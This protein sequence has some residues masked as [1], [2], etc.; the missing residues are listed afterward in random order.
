MHIQVRLDLEFAYFRH[1][2]C[3]D[4]RLASFSVNLASVY[5]RFSV[6][7]ASFSVNLAL[8][9]V[10]LLGWEVEICQCI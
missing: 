4:R 2:A 6:S 10:H 8:F 5:G 9:S 7:L 1:R 3:D